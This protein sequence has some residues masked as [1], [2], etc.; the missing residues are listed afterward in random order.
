MK[1]RHVVAGTGMLGLLLGTIAGLGVEIPDVP[2][3]P[4]P[5]DPWDR[6][7]DLAGLQTL[8]AL[9]VGDALTTSERAEYQGQLD[10]LRRD[11]RL[12]LDARRRAKLWAK[13]R[14]LGL[15]RPGA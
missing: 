9:A 3:V 4:P 11:D 7:T 5:Q 2:A 12:E 1:P 15:G 13:L 10:R 14:A 6:R 8:L